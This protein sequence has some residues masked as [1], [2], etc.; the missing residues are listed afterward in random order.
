MKG[1]RSTLPLNA[2]AGVALVIAAASLAGCAGGGSEHASVP[3][4]ELGTMELKTTPVEAFEATGPIRLT[5]HGGLFAAFVALED[6]MDHFVVVQGGDVFSSN[7]QMGWVHHPLPAYTELNRNYRY[8]V[9]DVATLLAHV[10]SVE[11]TP[12][13][14]QA[15]ANIQVGDAPTTVR[16]TVS[17]AGAQVSRIIIETGL[18]PESP[19]TLAP[20]SAA[21]PFDVRVPAGAKEADDVVAGDTA[22]RS[23]HAQI[24]GWIRQYKAQ[25]GRVPDTVD[26]NTL[27]VQRLGAAWPQNPYAQRDMQNARVSGDFTWARC[28]DQDASY[29][30]WG[31][32]GSPV[33][34]SFGRGCTLPL[35]GRS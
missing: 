17:H 25:I 27:A 28:S 3:F 22:A 35:F 6:R 34:D 26:A 12:D 30:G 11:A 5:W 13:G 33:G 24:I 15:V 32:D 23:G 31:W 1:P 4:L 7:L 14:F 10:E 2:R 29:I 8:L 16:L 9:W 18:D 21:L 20:S 19:Y